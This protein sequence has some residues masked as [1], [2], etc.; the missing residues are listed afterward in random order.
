MSACVSKRLKSRLSSRAKRSS[1]STCAPH[2]RK[3]KRR[4]AAAWQT[5]VTQLKPTLPTTCRVDDRLLHPSHRCKYLDYTL[6]VRAHGTKTI[7]HRCLAQSLKHA[8]HCAATKLR[9]AHNSLCKTKNTSALGF[10]AT[11]T[12]VLILANTGK[13]GRAC[14]NNCPCCS[15]VASS[16]NASTSIP[17]VER[18]KF[19]STPTR[20]VARKL[21]NQ[22]HASK[23]P[24][25][26]ISK[27]GQWATS[28]MEDTLEMVGLG[29]GDGRTIRSQLDARALCLASMQRPYDIRIS[30][31]VAHSTQSSAS[32]DRPQVRS[33]GRV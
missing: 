19:A 11:S 30:A 13:P 29:S 4:H 10:S 26:R 2:Q 16:I 12:H 18:K 6:F 31:H 3:V 9:V 8:H 25:Q 28:R 21:R 33:C 32:C 24:S 17:S 1:W 27:C 14:S 23:W 7:S 5:A 15:L 20:G 22:H